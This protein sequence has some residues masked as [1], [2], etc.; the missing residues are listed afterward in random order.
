MESIVELVWVLAG[1]VL[2]ITVGLLV[3][4]ASLLCRNG[5]LE[6]ELAERQHWDQDFSGGR[7]R[8]QRS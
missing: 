2:L 1:V 3:W 7:R 5:A 8:K 4:V 6:R